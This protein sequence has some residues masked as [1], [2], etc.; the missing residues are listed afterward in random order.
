MGLPDMDGG[1]WLQRYIAQ[2]MEHAK[3]KVKQGYHQGSNY[4]EQGVT[5]TGKLALTR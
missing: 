4:Q 3:R 1:A 5:C 2:C